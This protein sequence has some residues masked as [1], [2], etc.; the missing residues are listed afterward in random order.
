APAWLASE[1]TGEIRLVR[2]LPDWHGPSLPIHAIWSSGKLRGKA[3]LFIDHAEPAITAAC[4]LT[5]LETMRV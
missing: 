4:G 5:R 1:C 3:K 2:V